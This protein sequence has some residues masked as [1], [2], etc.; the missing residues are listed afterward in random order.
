[1]STRRSNHT[2]QNFTAWCERIG[3]AT[4]RIDYGP[5]SDYG[6]A[7]FLIF[8]NGR[9]CCIS[10]D[11]SDGGVFTADSWRRFERLADDCGLRCIVIQG[12]AG[13][14]EAAARSLVAEHFRLDLGERPL[15]DFP[16][17]TFLRPDRDGVPEVAE[18]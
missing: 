1:M 13:E 16:G 3:L 18:A 7:P 5:R 15:T 4:E 2:F 8:G 9:V 11:A 12:K 6:P 14:V 10:L 17:I